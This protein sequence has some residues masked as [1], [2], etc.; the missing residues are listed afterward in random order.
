LWYILPGALPD[1]PFELIDSLGVEETL[2]DYAAKTYRITDHMG[3]RPSRH[4]MT[5]I[6]L[7]AGLIDRADRFYESAAIDG[8][9]CFGFDV[10]AKKYG[11]NP[12]G[13]FHRVWFDA[14]TNLPVRMETHWPDDDGAGA[15]TIVQEQFDW[16][17]EYPGFL[18]P[19]VPPGFTVSEGES[20]TDT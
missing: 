6:L 12:D 9:K 20:R 19:Q 18:P 3:P 2:V 16:N 17:P 15:S 14:S 7:L 10:S 8:I 11:D 13:A 1:G 4:P 5:R